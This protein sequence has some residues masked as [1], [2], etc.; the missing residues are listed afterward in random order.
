[1]NIEK[2]TQALKLLETMDKDECNGVIFQLLLNKKVDFTTVSNAYVNA[3]ECQNKDRQNEL[4]EAYQCAIENFMSRKKPKTESDER[5]VQKTLYLLNKTDRY[6]MNEL[7]EQYSYN[8]EEGKRLF[9]H[10]KQ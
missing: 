1:M 2:I 9:E 6:Q 7:N 8:E 5:S 4:T 3:L 10:N